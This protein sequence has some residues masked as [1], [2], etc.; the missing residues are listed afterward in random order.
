MNQTE[1]VQSVEWTGHAQGSK[2]NVLRSTSSSCSNDKSYH[3]ERCLW[4]TYLST[5]PAT[6]HEVQTLGVR[7]SNILTLESDKL[8]VFKEG[9]KKQ[10]VQ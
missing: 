9:T 3:H 7:Q 4:S 8:G 6:P 2:V 10:N 5:S 1:Q